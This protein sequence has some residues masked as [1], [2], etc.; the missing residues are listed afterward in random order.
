[1]HPY[2]NRIIIIIIIIIIIVI[3]MIIITRSMH[4]NRVTG[5]RYLYNKNLD[6]KSVV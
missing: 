3:I 5:I 2:H 1:M 6:R 4:F